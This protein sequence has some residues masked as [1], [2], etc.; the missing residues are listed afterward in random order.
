[1]LSRGHRYAGL[2]GWTSA[3]LGAS[4]VTSANLILGKLM[5]KIA[6]LD[7]QLPPAL[8]SSKS[9]LAPIVYQRRFKSEGQQCCIDGMAE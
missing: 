3:S 2:Q 8:C 5:P 6:R 9:H 4:L 7:G 1:M